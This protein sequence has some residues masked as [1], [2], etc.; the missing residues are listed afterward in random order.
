MAKLNFL[1]QVSF[2]EKILFAKHLALMI[3]SGLPLR[4]G[5]ATIQKQVKNK[6]F[7]Q[8]LDNIVKRLDN[9]EPL[10][11]TLAQYPEVF[12]PLFYNI[13]SIGEAS[14]SL[15][16]NLEYLSTHLEKRH[17]LQRKVLSA[18]IYPAIILLSTSALGIILVTFVLP[19]L[20]T[21]FRRLDV[22]LPFTTKV[23][24][25][26]SEFIQN[27]GLFVLLGLGGLCLFFYLIFR[28]KS[29]KKWGH[30]MLLRIPIVGA[31]V[32]KINLA[33]FSRSL[34]TLLKSGVSVIEALNITADSVSNLTYQKEAEEI[35]LRVQ[36]GEQMSKYLSENE[37]FFPATFHRM[38]NVGE[39]TGNLGQSLL[40][41]AEFFE[42]EVDN[43]A[44]NLSTL[45]EPALLIGVGLAVAFVAVSIITPIYQITKG[46]R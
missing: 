28:L 6:N 29:V 38:I 39:K 22:E 19:K 43:T 15:E 5:V 31:F 41:L 12:N 36:R 16:Q 3:R 9:G 23:L 33:L 17:E 21:L 32:K 35:S 30:R 1:N 37:N 46:L 7:K 10:G 20:T 13:V 27:S 14:G 40:Y 45:V 26:L 34:G 44:E 2:V 24:I 8:I 4:E 42:D 18:M 25:W 11:E